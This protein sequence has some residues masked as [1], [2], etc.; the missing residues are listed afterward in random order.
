MNRFNLKLDTHIYI[1]ICIYRS[2]AAV[3]VGSRLPAT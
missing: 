3:S 2:T 1:Y